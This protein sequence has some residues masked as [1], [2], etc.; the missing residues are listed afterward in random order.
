MK[1]K[2]MVSIIIFV[3]LLVILGLIYFFY[4][5]L[6]RVEKVEVINGKFFDDSGKQLGLCKIESKLRYLAVT[7]EYTTYYY[8][9]NKN[10][11]GHCER[12]VH[13]GAGCVQSL[14]KEPIICEPASLQRS[15]DK[16]VYPVGFGATAKY[17]CVVE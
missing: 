2:K 7:P 12:R 3:A 9:S 15:C 14:E 1:K 4:L 17:G 6:Y 16:S 5:Y 8:D 10:D 13:Y 11:I